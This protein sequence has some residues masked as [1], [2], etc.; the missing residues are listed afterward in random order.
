MPHASNEARDLVGRLLV[1]E[2]GSRISAGE[3]K[4][5]PPPSPSLKFSNYPM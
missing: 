1:Y 4:F 2:S 5:Y 3:V